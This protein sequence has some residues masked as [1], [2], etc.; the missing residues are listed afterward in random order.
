MM[1]SKDGSIYIYNKIKDH[2]FFQNHSTCKQL[3]ISHQL[4]LTLEQL[5]SNGN[6]GLVGKLAQHFNVGRG[7]VVLITRQVIQA[8]DSYKE[9]YIKWPNSCR[10]CEISQVMWKEGFDGCMGFINGTKFPLC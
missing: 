3:P 6:A 7:T 8:I 4:A 5:G 9:E 2:S 1:T 10:R